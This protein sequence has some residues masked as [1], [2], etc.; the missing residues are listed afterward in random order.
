MQHR[1]W[2]AQAVRQVFRLAARDIRAVKSGVS[3]VAA[4]GQRSA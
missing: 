2:F 3:F 1:S 4:R